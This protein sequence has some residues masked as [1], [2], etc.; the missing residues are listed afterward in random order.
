MIR[1]RI[2]LLGSAELRLGS[3]PYAAE[4]NLK[5]MNARRK[6]GKRKV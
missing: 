2:L 5:Q 6:C 3:H 1:K 4:N